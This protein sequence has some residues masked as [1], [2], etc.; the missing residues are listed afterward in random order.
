M[1]NVVIGLVF[2]LLLFSLLATT[3]MELIS[4]VLAMRGKNLEN[5]IKNM[6]GGDGRD[7]IFEAFRSN[8]L[9]TQYTRRLSGKDRPPSYLSSRS[10][11]SIL[12]DVLFRGEKKDRFDEQITRIENE[13]LKFVLRHMHEEAGRDPQHFREG[14]EVWYDDVMDRASG[15]YKRN[16]QRWLLGVGLF[17]AVVFNADTIAIYDRL[18][19]SPETRIQIANLAR[20]QMNATGT[21]SL[22]TADGIDVKGSLNQIMAADIESLENPLGLGWQTF[23]GPALEERNY[24]WLEKLFGWLITALAVSLG[25]PFWFDLLRKIVN[26]RS[27]GSVSTSHTSAPSSSSSSAPSIPE[28]RHIPRTYG[29]GVKP[30]EAVG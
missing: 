7:E 24:F 6:L 2:I 28:E 23:K 12:L 9:Y 15:W 4:G 22:A 10:F 29:D 17:I 5:A 16:T 13:D 25:A 19:K 21:T 26:V 8:P 30:G 14:I 11:S 20:E 27:A 18:A 3:I 1:L